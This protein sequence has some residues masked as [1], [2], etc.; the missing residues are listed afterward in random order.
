MSETLRLINTYPDQFY[1]SDAE[2]KFVDG[3]LC[4]VG[5]GW[6]WHMESEA[7]SRELVAFRV[8]LTSGCQEPPCP[9]IPFP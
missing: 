6:V 2:I 1:D 9:E 4:E 3:I 7:V 5:I 8:P